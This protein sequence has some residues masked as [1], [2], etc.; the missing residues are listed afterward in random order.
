MPGI[1]GPSGLMD[2]H[3][4]KQIPTAWDQIHPNPC[5]QRNPLTEQGLRSPAR[6]SW[7][8]QR[9]GFRWSTRR[10]ANQIRGPRSLWPQHTPP[11]V[12]TPRLPGGIPNCLCKYPTVPPGKTV[13][14]ED[15]G[16]PGAW[17][18]SL[19]FISF[20]YKSSFFSQVQKQKF[21]CKNILQPDLNTSVRSLKRPFLQWKTNAAFHGIWTQDP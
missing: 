17:K 10:G 12:Q 1:W 2:K 11:T 19:T 15:L 20:I 16:S 3:T 6:V 14:R 4:D 7:V 9:A 18:R 5:T 8:A 21:S 13:G